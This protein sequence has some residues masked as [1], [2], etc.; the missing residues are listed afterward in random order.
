M[1]YFQVPLAEQSRGPGND[2]TIKL[3]HFA[4]A[5]IKKQIAR[6]AAPLGDLPTVVVCR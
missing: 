3:L 6:S 1:R 4:A 2:P 5:E